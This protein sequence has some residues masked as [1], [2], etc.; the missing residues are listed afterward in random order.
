[1]A[2]FILPRDI[3]NLISA[4]LQKAVHSIPKSIRVCC[5]LNLPWA[6]TTSP[7][8]IIMHRLS[9]IGLFRLCSMKPLR[10]LCSLTRKRNYSSRTKRAPILQLPVEILLLVADNL[11]LHD[12]FVLSQTCRALRYIMI[13]DWEDEISRLSYDDELR[14]WAGLASTLPTCWACPKCCKL[15]HLDIS[16]I[17]ITSFP[18]PSRLPCGV[19]LSRRDFSGHGYAIQHHHIQTALKLSPPGKRHEKYFKA[20][21]VPYTH[22]AE[23]YGT[24]FTETYKAEPRIINDRFLLSEKWMLKNNTPLVLPFFRHNGIWVCPHLCVC[25][26]GLMSSRSWKKVVS[27][28][29]RMKYKNTPFKE[30]LHLEDGITLALK[31]LGERVCV[32]CPRCPTDCEISVSVDERMAIIRAWHDFG[33]QGSPVDA[34]WMVHVKTSAKNDWLNPGFGVSYAQGS[35]RKLWDTGISW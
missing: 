22:T 33:M 24:V 4:T 11:A 10:Y 5:L 18:R 20:L 19:D 31:S 8:P 23:I 3:N 28:I 29:A 30:I 25:D 12:M 2:L 26:G 17:P 15:H 1:M 16:D 27:G 34:S 14:F 7:A 35:V 21:M 9:M 32:S 6:F 13:H